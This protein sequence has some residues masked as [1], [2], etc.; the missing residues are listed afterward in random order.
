MP[1]GMVD[2]SLIAHLIIEKIL[3]HTPIHRFRK[4]TQTSWYR[5]CFGAKAIQLVSLRSRATNAFASPMP[6][7]SVESGVSSMR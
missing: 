3:F 2:E 6:I 1:K 4:K 7:R 5:L